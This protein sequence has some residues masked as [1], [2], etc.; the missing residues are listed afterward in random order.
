MMCYYLNVHFH[1]QRVN[2]NAVTLD[3]ELPGI[4]G[5]KW[6]NPCNFYAY[7]ALSFRKYCLFY[8]LSYLTLNK[9]I[10]INM[11]YW[12]Q[13]W[14]A[15]LYNTEAFCDVRTEFY[16]SIFSMAQVHLVRQDLLSVE[17]LRSHLDTSHSVGHLWTNDEPD[18]ETSTWQDA[19]LTRDRHPCARR[20]SK[21]QSQKASGRRPTP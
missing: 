13:L 8:V 11:H 2:F 9:I 15:C 16:A 21:P 17:A 5:V 18:A 20:D 7:V 14:P 3:K 4:Q 6:S 19:T 12:K 10:T 1:G